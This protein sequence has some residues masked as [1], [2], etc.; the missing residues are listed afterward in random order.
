MITA[1]L[2]LAL[3]AVSCSDSTGTV[4]GTLTWQYNEFIGTKGDVG[5]KVV[6][7]P[8]T[9][10]FSDKDTADNST[11]A[12]LLSQTPQGKNGIYTTKADGYGHYEL[13]GIPARSYYLVFV[14]NNATGYLD[15]EKI[16]LTATTLLK[17]LFTADEWESL[18]RHLLLNKHEVRT[19]D[20]EKG[21]TITESHDFGYTAMMK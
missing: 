1:I 4:K 20:V 11:F 12:V 17:P 16:C 9:D 10:E 8:A 13:S 14:S 6:L 21:K 18:E 19:V 15:K 7:I 5:A 3:S 2:V